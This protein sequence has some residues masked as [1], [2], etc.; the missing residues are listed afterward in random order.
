M[1]LDE[2]LRTSHTIAVMGCSAYPSRTS[3]SIARYLIAAGYEVIPVNPN[4]ETIHGR[5][6]YPDLQAIP[7]DI[8]ID[9]VNIFRRPAHT[10]EMVR[11]AV[12]RAERLGERPAIWTQIGVASAEA[13]QIAE[14]AGLPYVRNRCIL[15]EHGRY[16]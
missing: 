14:K 13:E 9:I 16:F 7:D 12:E 6:C 1:R 2:L 11:Q 15:V 4:H 10:A 3:N 5:S 8:R